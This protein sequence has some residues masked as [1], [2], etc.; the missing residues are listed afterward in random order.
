MASSWGKKKNHQSKRTTLGLSL[1]TYI[2]RIKLQFV[3]LDIRSLYGFKRSPLA[4]MVKNTTITPIPI[5]ICH[6]KHHSADTARSITFIQR[7]Y[8]KA[9]VSNTKSIYPGINLSEIWFH[10]NYVPK[11]ASYRVIPLRMKMG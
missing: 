3:R 8:K 4:V 1:H 7:Y 6:M 11:F 10:L 2:F 9:R 5:G